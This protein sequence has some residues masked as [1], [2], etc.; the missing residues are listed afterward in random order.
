MQCNY[1]PA[2]GT[3]CSPPSNLHAIPTIRQPFNPTCTASAHHID[4]QSLTDL[5]HKKATIMRKLL[6]IGLIA[7]GL[8]FMALAPAQAEG[9]C[10]RYYYRASDGYCYAKDGY[11]SRSYGNYGYGYGYGYRSYQPDDSYR[12]YWGRDWNDYG[13][14]SHRR[15]Y[16]SWY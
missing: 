13:Y 3:I 11:S 2:L 9:G 1:G 5:I 15:G 7:S 8:S 10:G 4:E 12:R 6:V 16:Q 14:G